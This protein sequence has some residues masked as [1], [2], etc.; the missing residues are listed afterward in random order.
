LD[1][2]GKEIN[3]MT[4]NK[5]S[6]SK[7]LTGVL[8]V[9]LAAALLIGGGTFSYLYSSTEKDTVN[10]FNPNLVN[11]EINE[12][13]DGQYQII[14][15][16][17]QTKDP[18]VKVNASV[19][20]YVYLYVTD[21]TEELVEYQIDT[22]TWTEIDNSDGEWNYVLTDKGYSSETTKIY[23]TKAEVNETGTSQE[24]TYGV[25]VNDTVSYNSSLENGDMLDEDGNLRKG[26]ALTFSAEAV[27]AEGFADYE[28]AL[29]AIHGGVR[30]I[31]AAQAGYSWTIDDENNIYTATITGYDGSDKELTIP[32]QIYDTESNHLYTV[33]YIADRAFFNNTLITSVT[34]PSGVTSIG[35]TSTYLGVFEGCTNLKSVILPEGLTSIG[36]WAFHKC[37][38]LTE[39]TIP[40][41]V[42]SIGDWAFDYCTGL[43]SINLPTGLTSIGSMAFYKCSSLTEITIPSGVESIGDSAFAFCSNLASITIPS[44]VTSIGSKAFYY[45]DE[46][47]DVN[48]TGRED[49]WDKIS[50][51]FENDPLTSATI[52]YN[53][54]PDDSANDG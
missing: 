41:S 32:S 21:T 49:E 45:C 48:Y 3:F 7:V 17:A 29:D 13:G 9:S 5:K 54:A 51:G 27:Q 39:I 23:Y 19:D 10:E 44:S 12:S 6:K 37:S 14:P 28:E 20:S 26:L 4:E 24:L 33:T 34:I 43:T 50:I 36:E 22:N 35:S 31:E 18:T 2:S 53:Y 47:T 8:A 15:G 40:D 46:L 11:G 38:S 42:T 52:N 16:T 25:L 30:A 1:N